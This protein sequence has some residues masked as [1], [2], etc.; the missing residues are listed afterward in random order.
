MCFR[1]LRMLSGSWLPFVSFN[2]NRRKMD[3]HLCW[4]ESIFGYGL[5]VFRFNVMSKITAMIQLDPTHCQT[6]NGSL[7]Q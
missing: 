5:R 1:A 6:P 3:S 7:S 2:K 4:Y